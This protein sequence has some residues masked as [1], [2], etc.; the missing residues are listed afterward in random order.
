MLH[1]VRVRREAEELLLTHTIGYPRPEAE[2]LLRIRKGE[3]A[4]RKVAEM[5]E[6]GLERLEE[7]R[8][9]S[10]PPEEPDRTLAEELVADVYQARVILAA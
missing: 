8:E 4:Y 9:I 3:L 7:C 2:L 10:T 5:L 1:A 6:A